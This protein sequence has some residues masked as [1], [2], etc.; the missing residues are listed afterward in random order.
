V[1]VRPNQDFKL[2]NARS[3]LLNLRLS[4]YGDQ[5]IKFL[6]PGDSIGEEWDES[7]AGLGH[8]SQQG[9]YLYLSGMVDMEN[10]LTVGCAGA[11]L[12]HLHRLRSSAYLPGDNAVHALFRVTSME[13][14]G[15]KD[16]M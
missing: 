12:T 1:E 6:V 16:T 8:N 15:L 4:S 3:K 11:V 9:K 10:S 2:E 7:E 14:F 5:I 13:M